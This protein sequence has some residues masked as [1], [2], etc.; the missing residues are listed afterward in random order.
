MSKKYIRIIIGALFIAVLAIAYFYVIPD[1]DSIGEGPSESAEEEDSF[2]IIDGEKENLV[3]IELNNDNV[4]TELFFDNGKWVVKGYENI[5]LDKSNT[6]SFIESML[7]I[8]AEEVP[9]D[10]GNI[11]RYGLDNP[12]KSVCLKFKDGSEKLIYIGDQTPDNNYCYAKK[13]NED[14]VYTINH[15]NGERAEYTINYFVDKSIPK[16]SPYKIMSL[17]IKR[18]NAP[19]IDLEYTLQKQGNAQN[20]IEM[21]METMNMKKPYEGMAVYPSNLQETVLVNLNDIQLG[22]I[23]Q[24]SLENIDKFGFD[25]PEAE[26]IVKDDTNSLALTVGDKVQDDN[27]YCTVNDKNAVFLIDSKYVNPFLNAD[28]IKFVEKFVALHYRAEIERADMSEGDTLLEVTFGEEEAKE[29]SESK[30]SRFNDDRKAYLN[31]VEFDKSSFSDFFELL[32]GIT[33]D[34]VDENAKAVSDNPEV[35]IKYTLIDGSFDEVK[36]LPFNES[37]YIVENRPIEGM[38]VCNQIIRRV[39]EKAE[40]LLKQTKRD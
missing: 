11:G 10:D 40:N 17:N 37:F 7:S 9:N 20:L 4:L 39:F 26:I 18:K 6:E 21:G 15:I 29:N 38:L 3:S 25:S 13:P 28:P 27:Y 23:V 8:F 32:A 1:N 19:E 31:G 34:K 5:E 30:N 2:K 12:K 35:V 36:F 22:D 16:V 14:M 33:F 24:A